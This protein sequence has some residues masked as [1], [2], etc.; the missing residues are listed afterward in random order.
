M[1]F[2]PWNGCWPEALQ[3]I[4]LISVKA[5]IHQNPSRAS[6]IARMVDL[7]DSSNPGREPQ[8]RLVENRISKLSSVRST[9]RRQMRQY[10]CLERYNQEFHIAARVLHEC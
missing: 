9:S 2:S 3:R 8:V 1:D 6:V 5:E 4:A 10:R 7:N